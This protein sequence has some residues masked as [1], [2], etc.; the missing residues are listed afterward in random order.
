MNDDRP[1]TLRRTLA[2][3]LLVTLGLAACGGDV[4]RVAPYEPTRIIAIGD[5]FSV[6]G[7]NKYTINDATNCAANPVWT[8]SVAA[9]Y[10]K[11]F[12][13][14]PNGL[15]TTG[16]MLA[17]GGAKVAD[18]AA[19]AATLGSTLAS[20]DLVLLMAGSNDVREIF[21]G[22]GDTAAKL[23]TAQARGLAYA[24]LVNDLIARGARVIF[25]T[26]PDISRSPW[27]VNTSGNAS[28]VGQLVEA[29]N[30]SLRMNVVQDG[31]YAAIVL[32]DSMVQDA[33]LNPLKYSLTDITST[34]C[35]TAPPN[36]T[37]AT[38]VSGAS[39]TTWMWAGDMYLGPTMQARLGTLALERAQKNPF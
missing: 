25:A 38:L 22:A 7:A 15:S 39:A 12:A 34:A 4:S 14:C 20:T 1:M 33:M 9:H 16:V 24:A 11:S 6:A 17:A 30:T 32:A 36:C 19:Q 37:M 31:R 10:A 2:A 13:S 18:A 5:D 29:F 26:V 35:A 23:A 21:A 8:Q 28:L 3:L 27:G